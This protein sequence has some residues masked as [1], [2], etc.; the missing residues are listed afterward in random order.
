M[1][2]NDLTAGQSATV[3]TVGGSGSL[4]QHFL[5]MGVVPGAKIKL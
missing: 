4:R 5:D 1:T 3:S 2:L